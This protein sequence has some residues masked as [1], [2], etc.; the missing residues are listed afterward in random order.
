M[1]AAS[2]GA[3]R[4][5]ARGVG[6]VATVIAAAVGEQSAAAQ[7]IVLNVTQAAAGTAEVSSSI[8]G[9]AQA[10]VETGY[11]ASQVLGAASELSWQS[12][13]LGSVVGRFLEAALAA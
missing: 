8:A 12:E 5:Q 4:H 2:T 6:G 9:V 11:A 1:P 7:E 13:Y 10:A 3:G